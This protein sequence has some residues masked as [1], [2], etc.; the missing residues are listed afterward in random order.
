MKGHPKGLS[1]TNEEG[2]GAGSPVLTPDPQTEPEESLASQRERSEHGSAL[3]S[4][5]CLR[6]H[7]GGA[8]AQ[9]RGSLS[10]CPKKEGGEDA[11]CDNTGFS[12]IV[13]LKRVCTLS[14]SFSPNGS[15]SFG[16]S[17]FTV[18]KSYGVRER[19]N[20]NFLSSGDVES[21][22][23]GVDDNLASLGLCMY[24]VASVDSTFSMG[25]IRC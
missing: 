2:Q 21:E 19:R 8:A 1:W 5:V 3:V 10:F 22:R 13:G 9:L 24:I 23:G 15:V 18:F 6:E 7:G 20:C 4:L 14:Y 25:P 17:I 11:V 16:G 12:Q